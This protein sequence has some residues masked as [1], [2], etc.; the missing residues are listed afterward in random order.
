MTKMRVDLP[1]DCEFYATNDFVYV[2]EASG[3]TTIY[4]KKWYDIFIGGFR[5]GEL[6]RL[7]GITLC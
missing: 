2:F 5:L 1:N 6:K 4:A 3:C 7:E